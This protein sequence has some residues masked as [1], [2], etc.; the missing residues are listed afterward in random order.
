MKYSILL[1]WTSGHL[2]VYYLQYL[3]ANLDPSSNVGYVSYTIIPSANSLHKQSISQWCYS[4]FKTLTFTPLITSL[5][6]RWFS[7]NVYKI[8]E[9]IKLVSNPP[10]LT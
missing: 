9:A 3:L 1:V 10:T 8:Y 6:E 4:A 7:R 2:D 5:V